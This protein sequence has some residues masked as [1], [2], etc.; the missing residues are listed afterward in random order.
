MVRASQLHR[1]RTGQGQ[2][3]DVNLLAST[4]GLLP[5]MVAH[6]FDSGTRPGR[7][8]NRN[9][10]LAPAEALQTKDGYAIVVVER[11]SDAER[12]RAG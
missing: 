4:L 3:L 12:R 1:F 2:H 7:E 9:P 11:E 5:D 10:L 6:Y 8:G